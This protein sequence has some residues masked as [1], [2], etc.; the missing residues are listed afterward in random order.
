MNLTS[1]AGLIIVLV[2]AGAMGAVFWINRKDPYRDLRPMAAFSRLRRAI[3]MA[4]EDGSRVHVSLGSA[5]LIASNSASALVGLTLLE[6]VARLSSTSDL[7]PVVTSG[8][9]PLALLSQGELRRSAAEA[10]LMDDYDPGLSRL[11]GV[12]PYSYAAGAIPVINDGQ[13]ST[14]IALGNFGPE[15]GLMADAAEPTHAFYLAGSDS[16]TGQAVLFAAAQDPLIGEEL[17]AG[18]AYLQSG[19]MHAASLHAQDLFR[20]GI[21]GLLILGAIL[22]LLGVV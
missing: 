4:V 11:T 9:A 13:I 7:P 14:N 15:A 16:V 19:E 2:F 18:G 1:I 12:T 22:K 5:S 21:A 20:W 10:N 8:D 3:G 17:F 6:R